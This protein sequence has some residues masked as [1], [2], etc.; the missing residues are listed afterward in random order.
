MSI[1]FS[2]TPVQLNNIIN[3]VVNNTPAEYNLNSE[4][5][6]DFGLDIAALGGVTLPA[7]TSF[8]PPNQ[9]AHTPGDLGEDLRSV[10]GAVSSPNALAPASSGCLTDL[11]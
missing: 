5:C 9:W 1:S 11:P 8:L 4:N 6:T 10:P 7:T 2:I 3:H